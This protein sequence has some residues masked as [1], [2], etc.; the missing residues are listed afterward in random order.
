MASVTGYKA[1]TTQLGLS[2]GSN[3]SAMINAA[4]TAGAGG[5]VRGIPGTTYYVDAPIIMP[6]STELNMTGCII[7]QTSGTSQR[8]MLRSAAFANARTLN[9]VA[10]TASSTT[11]TSASGAFTSAD[12]GKSVRIYIGDIGRPR[13][14]TTTIASVTNGTTVVLAAAP[15]TTV[16][17]TGASVGTRDS[18]VRIIG[19][20]WRRYNLVS[21]VPINNDQHTFILRRTDGLVVA[22][23]QMGQGTGKYMV[24][25]ADCTRFA[26][27]DIYFDQAPSDGV[28]VGG[29][30]FNGNIRRLAGQVGDDLF[31]ITAAD[32]VQYNDCSGDV[33]DIVVED[34][35]LYRATGPTRFLISSD[36][37]SQSYSYIN[38]RRV[39]MS[40]IGTRELYQTSTTT[41]VG[42]LLMSG[43][44]SGITVQQTSIFMTYNRDGGTS[45]TMYLADLTIR[46]W[47]PRMDAA[48]DALNIND[49][50]GSIII[51]NVTDGGGAQ[52]SRNIV[53]LGF[54]AKTVAVDRVIIRNARWESTVGQ[55][56]GVTMYPNVNVGYI[57]VD[58]GSF[59]GQAAAGN[60]VIDISGTCTCE[61]VT[62]RDIKTSANS[63]WVISH[64]GS[65]TTRLH[66]ENSK[67]Q[68]SAPF[69]T[70]NTSGFDIS[71]SNT[72]WGGTPALSGTGVTKPVSTDVR[73]DV[74]L[75]N[76]VATAL[77]FNTN[78]ARSCGVGPVYCDGTNWIHLATNATY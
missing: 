11:M 50:A 60:R 68:G 28:H 48:T 45:G 37:S 5:I 57:E 54:S 70:A 3:D 42:R 13:F 55:I 47:T 29:F 2:N 40:R 62:L 67:L 51:E 39:T 61:A 4:L 7:Q 15:D 25:I 56:R 36:S 46:D 66:I 38:V 64:G 69:R 71:G 10:I 17:I 52:T 16:A 76:K 21:A 59:G 33:S 8:N 23:E 41:P 78:A 53:V 20:K 63:Q 22:P 30:S 44:L 72:V 19:G 49:N 31:A 34:V 27:E 12:V 73:L 18:N 32:Y 9:D 24:F 6:S 14:F 26:V 35:T 65:G 74:G 1:G 43:V 77:A 75:I 58:G